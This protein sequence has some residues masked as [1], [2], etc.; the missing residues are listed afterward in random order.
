MTAF[1]LD[2]LPTFTDHSFGL[3]PITSLWRAGTGRSRPFLPQAAS[4]VAA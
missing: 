2:Y 1:L 4:G 3:S